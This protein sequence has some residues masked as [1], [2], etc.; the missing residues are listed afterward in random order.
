MRSNRRNFILGTG[1]ALAGNALERAG[2]EV[3][4]NT[5]PPDIR[6]LLQ[7]AGFNPDSPESSL[8]AVIA[9]PH[10]VTDINH[11]YHNLAF[12]DT[13]VAEL[14]GLS[15]S[16]T[17]LVIAGDLILSHS[18]A[19]AEP[20]YSTS[21]AFA[22]QEFRVAKQQMTRFRSS[23][24]LW[25]VPGNHDT[26]R[27]END[28]ELWRTELGTPPYQKS[29]LGGVPVFF[30]NSGHA[31]MMD[32]VQIQWF[33]NE[34]ST[35]AADQEVLI[36][37]HHASF[38]YLTTS[39][40][41]KRTVATAFTGHRAAVWIM[42]GHGHRFYED[43]YVNKGTRFIQGH[44][45]AASTKVW[46]EGKA[47]GYT[48]LGLQGGQIVCRIQRSTRVGGFTVLPPL[49]ALRF[50]NLRW[51]FDR[52]EY[53]GELFHEGFYDRRGR[54]LSFAAVDLKCQ[55]GRVQNII[56]KLNLARYGG[57]IRDF[58]ISGT[59]GTTARL[60][61]RCAF[62]T[63]G[64]SGPWLD[65]SIPSTAASD[66]NQAYR[67]PIPGHFLNAT[68]LFVKISTEAPSNLS[69]MEIA[70]WGTA[71]SS[72]DLTGYERWI[73]GTYRT[74]L[75]NAETN[76]LTIP[77]GSS[78]TNLELFAFNLAPSSFTSL[79]GAASVSPAI[80]CKPTYSR[81]L[82]ETPNTFAFARKRSISNP[83]VSAFLEESTNLK[84]WLP[85]APARLTVTSLDETWEEVRL[86]QAVS[87]GFFRVRLESDS[88]SQGKFLTWQN[89]VAI[90]GSSPSDRNANSI[91]D[92]LEY[93]FDLSP[94]D[95]ASRLYDSSRTSNPAGQLNIQS[96]VSTISRIVFARMKP[97][98]NPGVSYSLQMSSNLT[99]WTVVPQ[100]LLTE[101]IL[102]SDTSWEEVECLVNDASMHQLYYRVALEL[103]HPLSS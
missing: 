51:A 72:E 62:S 101:R 23:M 22:Q 61:A 78:L 60:T 96:R 28:A 79:S 87:N 8:L 76:P 17:D 43:C 39:C 93:A 57:K 10:F 21:Y 98:A 85:V 6:T 64:P 55:F 46:S 1:A 14:N 73:A 82:T 48:L 34:A 89:T 49:S 67:I 12:D 11:P 90:P 3:I 88:A 81:I 27:Q 32:P 95:G 63:S 77:P 19:K 40:G 47:P 5:A 45:T 42:S 52:I 20:R 26:D 86:T 69:D 44:V 30:L 9:D 36:I 7:S 99:D 94:P 41:L 68:D 15:P 84:D 71:A 58:L 4:T 38:A 53:P 70:G 50:S 13:F 74:F 80:Q 92:V 24:R 91:D 56:W 29:V 37:C 103:T 83:G 97:S 59:L 102:R 31:G 2:A 35:I 100:S 54:V 66:A 25:S 65:A 16:I 33:N 75:L 18:R